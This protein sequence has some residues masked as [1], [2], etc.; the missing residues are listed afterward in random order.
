MPPRT[1]GE[2]VDKG[3]EELEAEAAGVET[4]EPE[5][6]PS[7]KRGGRRR[8][9]S[10]KISAEGDAED[11]KE[12]LGGM[13]STDTAAERA[14]EEEEVARDVDEEF[15]E[16]LLNPKN[17]VVVFRE[18]PKVW[19]GERCGIRLEKYNCPTTLDRISDDIFRRFGG[20]VFRVAVH[21][22]T[23]MGESRLIDAVTISNPDT[24]IP[25][26]D[27]DEIGEDPEPEV[28]Q[29]DQF[30]IED[31]DPTKRLEKTIDDQ[32]TMT[33][34]IIRLKGA[35]RVMKQ[36]TDDDEAKVVDQRPVRDPSADRIRQLE[37]RIEQRDKDDLTNARFERLERLIVEA[38]T[39]GGRGSVD[40]S[41]T[42][43]IEMMKSSDLKFQTMM[44]T[45]IP[46]IANA[47]K[48]TDDLDHQLERLSK[49]RGVF[50]E[51]NGKLKGLE[52]KLMNI[53]LERLTGDDG[54]IGDDGLGKLAI[55]EGAPILK[56]LVDS[57][58]AKTQ[59]A[60]PAVSREEFE[61]AVATAAK[62][63]MKNAAKEW[64]EKGWLRLPESGQAALPQQPPPAKG[65]QLPAQPPPA[66]AQPKPKEIIGKEEDAETPPGPESPDYSRPDAVNFVLDTIL[67]EMKTQVE[68]GFSVGDILDRLDDE[69]LSG[70]LTVTSGEELDKLIGPFADP[71]KMI[72]IKT[73]GE[74]SL[75]AKQWLS[76]IIL[77][78]QTEFRK[79]LA[80]AKVR[81]A[82]DGTQKGGEE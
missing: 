66:A 14:E 3:I 49:L 55:K 73:A 7:K 71:K 19:R 9:A 53:A 65:P 77:T 75:P 18:T 25:L 61:K 78:A 16:L 21:P 17:M 35:K 64:S 54:P 56:S 38:Q 26:F 36:L 39:K 6:K 82:E 28:V 20:E 13:A 62:E 10:V 69:L 8:G 33:D 72:D 11:V 22:N 67:E 81:G 45:F 15:A 31:P 50:G 59:Q 74:I 52:E 23:A 32:I 4:S 80:A 30:M 5:E 43:M 76:R 51:G 48:K 2:E 58:L 42:L 27:G 57:Q 40:P 46:L 70:L 63:M 37:S 60:P 68:D 79:Q 44:T 1:Q 24:K 34:K 41:M 29:P 12:A 47:G